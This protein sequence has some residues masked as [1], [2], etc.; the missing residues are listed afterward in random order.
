MK[1]SL[2]KNWWWLIIIVVIIAVNFL[3]SVFHERIDLTNEKRFTISS[4]VKK[5]L[6]NL[7]ETVD[8]DIFLTGELPAG[9]K[10]L[11]TSAQELLQEF[12]E[13]SNGNVHY[14]IIS[15][16]DKMP[17]TER[18][19]ADTLSSLGIIPINL[20]I[21]LKAGEQSQYIYPAAIVTYKNKMQA[22]NLYSGTKTVITPPELNSAEALLEFKFAN[23]IHKIIENH[24]P[25][26]AYATGNGEPTGA[27]TYD[28]V[29]NVL[30]KNYSLFTMDLDREP[31]IPDT[32][33]LLIIVKPTKGFTDVE[34]LKIDQYVMHGG[35]L[36]CFI[37]RLEAETDSLQIKNQVVAYDRN[38]QLEDLFFKYGVRINPDL[39]MDLQC[40][41][42]PFSVNGKDQ[43]EFLHW[44]YFPL[45]ESK[46][47]SVI[48]KNVG[49]VAG[50]FVNSID[51]VSAPGIKKTI[52]L[53]SSNNSR[54]IETPA[55]ISGEE[56]RNSPI[57]TS[58]NKK[59]IIAGV[60][61]EGK[62]SSLY[63]NRIG[64]ATMD[65]LAAYGTPFLSDDINANKMI[66]I[67]DGD[68][69]LN[70]EYKDEPLPMGVNSYTV[71][72][73]YEYQFANKQFVE[74]C[75]EYL[76]NDADLSEAKSKDYKLRLLDPKKINE[77]RT[78]WQIVNLA[79]PVI[80]IIFFGIIY[81]WWRKR[82][83]ANT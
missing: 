37:D 10:K 35:K 62:F 15:A 17:G 34:K 11:S 57:D 24:K 28:L 36:L 56:N 43:F 76:I 59:D 49:L 50:R 27:N 40:D 46:Q 74:N 51:T 55:L 7:D 72:T 13:Y 6:K 65:S 81:Q 12:K 67:S 5:I 29:E 53:S 25:M 66:I 30:R 22:V 39:L 75:I 68:I 58:F 63:K 64:R 48:N 19:Y 69:P 44:N 42:L 77:Q 31:L 52:L 9:F 3:G 73:Q 41:F 80:L 45:F 33:K 83:Y 61:L 38:L 21:Q 8:V 4:P 16:D 70:G 54:T 1:S 14:K 32:F 47:N 23:A 26:V 20:K 78:F 79:L 82:K 18:T 2:N 60:L 71:G